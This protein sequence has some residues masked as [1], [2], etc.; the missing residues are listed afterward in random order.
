MSCAWLHKAYNI[1]MDT[2]EFPS[3]NAEWEDL[4]ADKR[5]DIF[6]CAV[7]HKNEA[8]GY[9]EHVIRFNDDEGTLACYDCI[10]EHG[11][12]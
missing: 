3:F 5:R 2:L 7:C 11:Q 4:Q 8:I 6:L 12:I 10:K 9:L 1:C